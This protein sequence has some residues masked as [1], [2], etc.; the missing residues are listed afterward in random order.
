M[1]RWGSREA[2]GLSAARL[3]QPAIQRSLLVA[4]HPAR[5]PTLAALKFIEGLEAVLNE[6]RALNAPVE[7]LP[8]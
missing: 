3:V 6:R 2:A 4:F 1:A 7:L 5:E 8:D